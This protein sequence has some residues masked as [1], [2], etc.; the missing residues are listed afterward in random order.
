MDFEKDI[1]E[2]FLQQDKAQAEMRQEHT[3]QKLAKDN[4][5][6]EKQAKIETLESDN[7]DERKRIE[8][9]AWIKIDELKDRNKEELTAIIKEGMKNKSD[10]QKETGTFRTKNTERETLMKEIKEKNSQSR[11]YDQAIIE[12]KNSIEAQKAELESRRATI[13]DKE[14]RIIELKKKT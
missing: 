5:Y 8:E 2:L 3:L 4:D 11:S 13:E 7:V 10:L 9:Q 1:Q 12:M 6:K 14:A